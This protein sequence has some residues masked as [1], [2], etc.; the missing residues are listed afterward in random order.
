LDRAQGIYNLAI[1]LGK[2]GERRKA[3]EVT[4]A[5]ATRASGSSAVASFRLS[6]FP[7]RLLHWVGGAFD[8]SDCSGKSLKRFL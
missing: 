2:G 6:P 3:K 5:E 8:F 1:T 7:F 4:A